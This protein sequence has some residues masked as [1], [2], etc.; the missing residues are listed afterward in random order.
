MDVDAHESLDARELDRPQPVRQVDGVARRAGRGP[1]RAVRKPA[2]LRQLVLVQRVRVDGRA[3]VEPEVAGEDRELSTGRAW[4]SSTGRARSTGSRS[5]I[6]TGVGQKKPWN[7]T[8]FFR[9]SGTLITPRARQVRVLR[10]ERRPARS[11]RRSPFGFLHRDDRRESVAQQIDLGAADVERRVDLEGLL[12]PGAARRAGAEVRRE[13]LGLP[14]CRRGS[15]AY[16][17]VEGVEPQLE[18]LQRVL[19]REAARA[20]YES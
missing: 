19:V 15:N 17:G 11:R 10:E 20:R 4:R 2:I 16:F 5:A 18:R 12:G 1:A 14:S 7:A 13:V 9:P 6:V 3:L 8:C